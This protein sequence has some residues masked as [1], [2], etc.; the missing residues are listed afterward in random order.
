[1]ATS[2]ERRALLAISCGH[3]GARPGERCFVRSRNMV[4]DSDRR[5]A[6][7]VSTLEAGMHSTRWQDALGREPRVDRQR[8]AELTPT[9]R[10]A[11]VANSAAPA[12]RP[13]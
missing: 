13:W 12:E 1:M 2:E 11:A 4:R 3:C 5:R 6:R 10:P 7:P 8:V 9:R